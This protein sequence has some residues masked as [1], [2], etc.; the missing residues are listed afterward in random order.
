[1]ETDEQRVAVPDV[2]GMDGWSALLALE[3]AGFMVDGTW[4]G[5]RQLPTGSFDVLAQSPSAGAEAPE[6]AAV[7]LEL[8]LPALPEYYVEARDESLDVWINEPITEQQATWIVWELMQEI[9]PDGAYFVQINCIAGSTDTWDNRQ[10]NSRFGV[11]AR[12]EAI[13]GL[14]ASRQDFEMVEGATCP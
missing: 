2:V 6:G 9:R 12:G 13:S 4:D 3:D 14:S 1:M 8:G 11:G 10:A 5:E 7:V